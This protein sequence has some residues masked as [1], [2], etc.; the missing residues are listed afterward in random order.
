MYRLNRREAQKEVI[1][2]YLLKRDKYANTSK[3]EI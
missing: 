1:Q 2:N 3:Q